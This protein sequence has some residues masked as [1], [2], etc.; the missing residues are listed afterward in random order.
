MLYEDWLR[1]QKR[2]RESDG[3]TTVSVGCVVKWGSWRDVPDREGGGRD[4]Y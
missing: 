4:S 2:E 1:V 3:G